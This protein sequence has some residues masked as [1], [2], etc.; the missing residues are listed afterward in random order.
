[1]ASE[2]ARLYKE[3]KEAQRQ[4]DDFLAMLAL[5]R[6]GCVELAEIQRQALGLG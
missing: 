1:M 3:L 2:N 6:K 5:A 4:K